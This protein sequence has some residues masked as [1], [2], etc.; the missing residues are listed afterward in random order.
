MLFVIAL[1][2][3]IFEISSAATSSSPSFS[4][5]AVSLWLQAV[6]TLSLLRAIFSP[7]VVVLL[8]ECLVDWLKHA[9]IT[10][11]N[12]LRPGVYGRFIDVLCKDLVASGS[13][14]REDQVCPAGQESFQLGL[15]LIGFCSNAAIRRPIALC[16]TPPRLRGA[17]ARLSRRPDHLAGVRDVGR[18]KYGRR[19]VTVGGSLASRRRC[20]AL[21]PISD[22]AFGD[23]LVRARRGM[24][25]L[26][27]ARILQLDLVST[28][29]VLRKGRM[30]MAPFRRSLV[31]LKL[32]IGYVMNASKSLGTGAEAGPFHQ[33]Q[34]AR[35]RFRTLG[36]HERP[37]LR[38]AVQQP[39][40]EEDRRDG[41]RG[42]EL[43]PSLL[44]Q[45]QPLTV[46]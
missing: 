40:A 44:S 6:P 18:R 41:A 36:D 11:F 15:K 34:L 10:K 46:S 12:H 14:D 25:S 43:I 8:S 35:F 37:D 27:C 7:A 4:M 28:G 5:P 31:A 29:C 38:G 22:L 32:L 42:G 39:S 23:R 33:R 24:G 30:L 9:F 26:R 2:N 3:L 20:R 21:F 17:S 45:A 1:R 16:C 13:S 19:D